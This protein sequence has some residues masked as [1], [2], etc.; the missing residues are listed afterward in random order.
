MVTTRSSHTKQ[1]ASQQR[2]QQKKKNWLE[3]HTKME[4]QAK[5]RRKYP[6]IPVGDEVK[7][8]KQKSV[9]AKE[10]VSDYPNNPVKVKK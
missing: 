10:V 9:H 7:V 6:E 5:H 1:L 4:I 8:Y 2:K 3:V